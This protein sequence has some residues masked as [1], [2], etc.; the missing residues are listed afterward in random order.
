MSSAS[1][2]KELHKT[3]YGEL[4][5]YLRGKSF[6]IGLEDLSVRPKVNYYYLSHEAIDE[7]IQL[8]S[9]KT[10]QHISALKQGLK[11]SL[12]ARKKT[13]TEEYGGLQV[14]K[15]TVDAVPMSAI[16]IVFQDKGD[17]RE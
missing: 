5:D 9:A 12:E 3:E 14:N 7:L 2:D 10:E 8:F 1:V 16:E 11:Q 13:F 6:Q 17:N 4:R 15:R